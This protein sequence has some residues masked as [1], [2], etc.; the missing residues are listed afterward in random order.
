M[1]KLR[2]GFKVFI[3]VFFLIFILAALL[4][5]PIFHVGQIDIIGNYEISRQE[6]LSVA[7]L[8]VGVNIFSFSA[9]RTTQLVENLPYVY[10]AS[11]IRQLPDRVAI[12]LRE[13]APVASITIAAA[14]TYLLIDAHGVV[15]SAHYQ[16]PLGLPQI[17]GLHF[18]E[19]IIGRPLQLDNPSL[20]E[21]VLQLCAVFI[22]YNFMP[23]LVDFSNS[24]DI[25]I[26][27][28]NFKIYIGTMDDA[29]TKIRNASEILQ[30]SPVDR[31]SLD[32]RNVDSASLRFQ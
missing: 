18:E 5:S 29:G 19:F 32:I 21:D 14:A 27:K 15:L 25:I 7:E 13:R 23:N 2:K 30:Q 8:S 24:R 10:E 20:L 31:G 28:G 12:Y 3:F 4:I 9:R 1:V 6:I 26:F 17:T 22:A 16:P 11:I